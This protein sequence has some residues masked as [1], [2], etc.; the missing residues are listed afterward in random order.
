MRA[1]A[2]WASGC[3]CAFKGL[4]NI[5]GAA[6]LSSDWLRH[7][8]QGGWREMLCLLPFPTRDQKQ[9][10]PFPLAL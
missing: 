8:E 5:L 3:L 1:R 4:L 7:G 10:H 2:R 6:T 9:Q